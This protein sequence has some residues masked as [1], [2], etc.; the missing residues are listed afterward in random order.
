MS[1]ADLGQI[2]TIEIAGE[3]GALRKR[4]AE[5][6]TVVTMA[7]L[8]LLDSNLE[9]IT[10]AVALI[11]GAIKGGNDLGRGAL[12]ERVLEGMDVDLMTI[13]KNREN[14]EKTIRNLIDAGVLKENKKK[15]DA[16]ELMVEIVL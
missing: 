5:G 10:Q 7:E 14:V 11:V 3:I 1:E 13:D 15:N 8:E 9:D 12:L 2:E 6:Q 16:V 4:I